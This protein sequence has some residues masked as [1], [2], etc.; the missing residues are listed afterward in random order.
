MNRPGG[1]FASAFLDR[2]ARPRL[3]KSAPHPR[4]VLDYDGRPGFLTGVAAGHRE[5]RE[6]V[7]FLACARARMNQIFVDMNFLAN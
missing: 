1:H 6:S 5:A 7:V 3:D 4:P 2:R